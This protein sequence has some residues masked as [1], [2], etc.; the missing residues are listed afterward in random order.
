MAKRPTPERD[1]LVI[2]MLLALLAI[3]AWLAS[4]CVHQTVEVGTDGNAGP[5][6]VVTVQVDTA[7][8]ADTTRAGPVAPDTIFPVEEEGPLADHGH[9]TGLLTGTGFWATL[10]A[11]IS[12]LTALALHIW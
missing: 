5:V 12:G 11:L 2:W 4:A 1:L 6:R 10:T 8:V 7:V 9:R 3:M